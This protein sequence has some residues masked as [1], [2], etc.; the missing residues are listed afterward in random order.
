M[1]SVVPADSQKNSFHTCLIIQLL[2]FATVQQVFIWPPGKHWS[3]TLLSTSRAV[4]A[5]VSSI[6]SLIVNV[7]HGFPLGVLSAKKLR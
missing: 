2:W 4:T 3:R 1:R 7:I 6:G 5:T